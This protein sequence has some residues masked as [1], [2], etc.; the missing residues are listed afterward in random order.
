MSKKTGNK[1]VVT[2]SVMPFQ[3]VLTLLLQAVRLAVL[4]VGVHTPPGRESGKSRVLPVY[5]Y[6]QRDI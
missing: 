6:L 1:K 2:V 5:Q 3:I 4:H